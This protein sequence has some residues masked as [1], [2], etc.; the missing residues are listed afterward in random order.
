MQNLGRMYHR[1]WVER[2]NYLV[3]VEKLIINSRSEMMH[4]CK[5]MIMY[6]S[7]SQ[8]NKLTMENVGLRK[9]TQ[10]Y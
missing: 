2:K 4:E 5:F 3:I 9:L 8:K 10:V 6:K 7:A 1:C